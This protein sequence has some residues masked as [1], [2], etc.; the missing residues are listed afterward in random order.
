MEQTLD[1]EHRMTAVEDRSKSNT[2][3]QEPLACTTPMSACC[4]RTERFTS[5]PW[6]IIPGHLTDTPQVGPK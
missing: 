2:L 4:G 5:L 1:M 3:R 6:T